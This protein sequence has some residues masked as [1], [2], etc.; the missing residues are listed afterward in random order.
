MTEE[1]IEVFNPPKEFSEKAY[2]KSMEQYEEMY[3]RSMEDTEKFWAEIAEKF[4]WFEKWGKVRSYN[5]DVMKG[6]L[7]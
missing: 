3:K 4:H 1:K 7:T 5:Y 6:I 2:I